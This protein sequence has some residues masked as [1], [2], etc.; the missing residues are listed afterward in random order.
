M[1]NDAAAG[2]IDAVRFGLFDAE[3]IICDTLAGLGSGDVLEIVE[4]HLG[5]QAECGDDPFSEPV[6]T[7]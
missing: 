2:D 3:A 4:V 5:P 1:R 6:D 7:N